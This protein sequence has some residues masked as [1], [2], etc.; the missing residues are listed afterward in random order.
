MDQMSY[1]KISSKLPLTVDLFNKKA[2]WL[3]LAFYLREL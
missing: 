1:N 3:P 2:E